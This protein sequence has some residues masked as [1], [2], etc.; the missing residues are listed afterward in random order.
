MSRRSSTST[1]S[2]GPGGSNS[3]R[4]RPSST[5]RMPSTGRVSGG[6]LSSPPDY[7]ARQYQQQQ[8]QGRSKFPS[9][10][11]HSSHFSLSEQR[12]GQV[13][14]SRI[15]SDTAEAYPYGPGSRRTSHVVLERSPPTNKQV[16]CKA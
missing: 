4:P 9:A 1:F 6:G 8:Q 3:R 10:T 16:R 5:G 15:F 2:T 12:R 13:G 11:Q 7:R 14:S